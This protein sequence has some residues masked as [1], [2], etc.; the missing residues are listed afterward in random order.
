PR[1][2]F[3]FALNSKTAV[4]G[5]YGIFY[6]PASQ[7]LRSAWANHQG[8]LTEVSE[9]SLNAGI[10]PALNWGTGFPIPTF[11]LSRKLD[12]TIGNGSATSFIGS[13]TIKPPRIQEISF[14]IQRQLPGNLLVEATYLNNLAHH[15]GTV[16]SEQVNQLDYGRYGSL[17]NLLAADITS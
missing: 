9:A 1:L 16:N 15:I 6:G 12:P 13:G 3:A 5:G 11:N 2:G 14:S 17:G 7:A 4:R 8:F 10:T